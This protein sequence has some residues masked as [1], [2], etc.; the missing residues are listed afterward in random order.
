[1]AHTPGPW[2]YFGYEISSDEGDSI[3]R[4]YEVEGGDG[5][6]NACLIAAAP[7]LLDA[8]M[9]AATQMGHYGNIANWPA[10]MPMEYGD[11]INRLRAAI[12]K[13]KEA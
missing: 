9:F 12:A 13:A 7:D 8:S 6:A 11:A 2:N 3:A 1:M 5:E 4:W 10:D